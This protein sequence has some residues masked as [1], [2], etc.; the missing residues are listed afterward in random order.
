MAKFAYNN[1]KNAST[2]HI[3]F[4]LNCGYHFRVSFGEDVDLRSKSRSANK[5]AGELRELIEFYYQNL[6]YAQEL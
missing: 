5:L 3:L 6:L 1:A 4:K 2:S